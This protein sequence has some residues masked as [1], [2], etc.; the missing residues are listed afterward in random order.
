[1]TNWQDVKWQTN[2]IR[3]SE[4]LLKNDPQLFVALILQ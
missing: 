3:T 4:A 1:M 2:Y